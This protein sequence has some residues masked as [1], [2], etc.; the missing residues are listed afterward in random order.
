M[1]FRNKKCITTKFFWDYQVI[2]IKDKKITAKVVGEREVEYDGQVY[3]LSP[4]VKML[5]EQRG[6]LNNSGAYQGAAYFT[7][8]GKKLTQL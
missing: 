7:F 6:E 1:L 5:F 4:L 8:N 3:K 2:F